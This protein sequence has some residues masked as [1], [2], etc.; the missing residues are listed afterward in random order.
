MHLINALILATNAD[1]C[2]PKNMFIDIQAINAC[3]P[4]FIL[5]LSY[6]YVGNNLIDRESRL[7]S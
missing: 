4:N 5:R 1:H 7:M 3:E 2:L 6:M